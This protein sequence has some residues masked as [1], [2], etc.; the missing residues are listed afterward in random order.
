MNPAKALEALRGVPGE[1]LGKAIPAIVWNPQL[2][3]ILANATW[4]K[5]QERSN[6]EWLQLIAEAKGFQRGAGLLLDWVNDRGQAMVQLCLT[7]R[8]IP[9]DP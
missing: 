3:E 2:L 1:K 5:A 7:R 6:E 8:G 9:S 4:Q